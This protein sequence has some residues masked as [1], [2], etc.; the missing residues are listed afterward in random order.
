HTDAE[1]IGVW[2]LQIVVEH[3]QL[4]AARSDG[5]LRE[6]G[7][8]L[9]EGERVALNTR[10]PDVAETLSGVRILEVDRDRRQRGLARFERQQAEQVAVVRTA[11]TSVNDVPLISVQVI[12]YTQPR[13]P[14]IV[15]VIAIVAGADI[16]G[17]IDTA[18]QQTI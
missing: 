17:G 8:A 11:R 10:T 16:V 13:C 1:L 2:R 14:S 12:R 15:I 4:C 3:E 9:L 6:R 7:H 18:R 5:D